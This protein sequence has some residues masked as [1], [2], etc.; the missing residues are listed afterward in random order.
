MSV[1]TNEAR[2]REMEF[3]SMSGARDGGAWAR[4]SVTGGSDG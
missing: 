3:L 4:A 2:R 1:T